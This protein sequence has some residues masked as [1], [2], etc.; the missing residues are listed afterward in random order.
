MWESPPET[1]T[2]SNDVTEGNSS[3]THNQRPKQKKTPP[4]KIPPTSFLQY[5]N[6]SCE[7]LQNI[8]LQQFLRPI[9]CSD[10]ELMQQLNWQRENKKETT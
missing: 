6:I 8:Y 4:P 5:C 3:P 9:S 1:R 2:P 10:T 7:Q